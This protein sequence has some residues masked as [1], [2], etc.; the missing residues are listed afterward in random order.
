MAFTTPA[1]HSL[2][3]QGV[4]SSFHAL[5]AES[6]QRASSH[7]TAPTRLPAAHRDRALPAFSL[8]L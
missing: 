7:V 6:L 2:K 4:S 5:L 8:Y 1:G 3:S